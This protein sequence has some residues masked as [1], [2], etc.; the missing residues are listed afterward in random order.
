VPKSTATQPPPLFASTSLVQCV[1]RSPSITAAASPLLALALQP[2]R[3]NGGPGM[4]ARTGGSGSISMSATPFVTACR[5]AS[6]AARTRRRRSVASS[7]APGR[8]VS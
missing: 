5:R 7:R 4:P 1:A 6:G 3:D 2:A 8:P